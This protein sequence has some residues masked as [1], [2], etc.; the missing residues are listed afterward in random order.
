MPTSAIG[1]GHNSSGSW[2]KGGVASARFYDRMLS[3]AE[4]AAEFARLRSRYGR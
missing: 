1:I 2:W 4:L 3:E